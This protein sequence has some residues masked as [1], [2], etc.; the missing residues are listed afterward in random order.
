MIIHS[1]LVGAG[2]FLGSILRYLTG[3]LF[4]HFVGDS[5]PFATLTV[6]ILGCFAISL[7]AKASNSFSE[8]T[9]L[10]AMMGL[11]GGF[12]TFSAFGL[13]TFSLFRDQNYFGATANIALNVAGGSLAVW[14][15]TKI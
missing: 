13:E 2:G 10:F 4:F 3:K 11:L 6:N 7:F 9:R 8:G 14:V 15:G 12:T 1:L 5:F